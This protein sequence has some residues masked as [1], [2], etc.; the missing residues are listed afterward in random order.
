M[1]THEELH[2]VWM[3]AGVVLIAVMYVRFKRDLGK[4]DTHVAFVNVAYFSLSCALMLIPFAIFRT[5]I[6]GA[7]GIA[8]EIVHPFWDG[9]ALAVVTAIFRESWNAYQARKK[10]R[11]RRPTSAT[12]TATSWRRVTTSRRQTLSSR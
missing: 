12:R 3:I 2:L 8:P 4:G 5:L 11:V 6:L 10:V 1:F 9:I 7:F